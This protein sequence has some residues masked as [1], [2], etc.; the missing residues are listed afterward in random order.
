[1]GRHEE[2]QGI[3]EED[4]TWNAF[5][6]HFNKICFLERYFDDRAK[7]FYELQ[8]VSMTNQECTSRFLELLR[9]VPYLR[10][11][12]VKFHRFISGLPIAYKD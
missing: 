6:R 9:Y 7:D 5:E 3:N 2:C 12:K 1:M 4:L 10:E 11:E 8:M